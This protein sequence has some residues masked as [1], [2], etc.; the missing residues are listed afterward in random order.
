MR[1][2]LSQLPTEVP[3]AK[4]STHQTLLSGL[5]TASLFD[6]MTWLDTTSVLRLMQM[7]NFMLACKL[8]SQ[9]TSLR[10]NHTN[11]ERSRDSFVAGFAY[12]VRWRWPSIFEN[13]SHLLA[14]LSSL[15]IDGMQRVIYC[16]LSSLPPSLTKLALTNITLI[17]TS[18]HS[19]QFNLPGL[20]HLRVER[21]LANVSI[22]ARSVVVSQEDWLPN[23]IR[24]SPSIRV[25]RFSS[26]R[27]NRCMSLVINVI[28]FKPCPCWKS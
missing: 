5:D 23:S 9:I 11:L 8:K 13:T 25:F 1:R 16:D 14:K 17:A 15:S 24:N 4:R 21:V 27:F 20:I 2:R 22:T 28:V 6:L 3:E 10:Y 7:G 19:L 26:S 12:T 18:T